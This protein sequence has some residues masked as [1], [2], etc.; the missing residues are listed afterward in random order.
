MYANIICQRIK[1]MGRKV[2]IYTLIFR[3]LSASIYTTTEEVSKYLSVLGKSVEVSHKPSK[4]S[5]NHNRKSN[6]D[7]TKD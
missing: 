5:R 3:L 6:W 2:K 4:L 1:K 7:E